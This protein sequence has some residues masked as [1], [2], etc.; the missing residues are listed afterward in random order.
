MTAGAGTGRSWLPGGVTP[1]WQGITVAAVGIIALGSSWRS[2]TYS[3]HA[4]AAIF[5]G[6]PLAAAALIYQRGA[7]AQAISSLGWPL[8]V[9][10]LALMNLVPGLNPGHSTAITT[11]S[12][13]LA[14]ASVALCFLP[15]QGLA[16]IVAAI[17]G[18]ADLALA[19]VRIIWGHATI[20]VFWFTQGA[21]AQLLSGH[22]P[23]A[24]AYST[25]T[26]GLASAHFPY[27]P[28][29]LLLAAPFRLLGDVRLTNAAAMVTVFACV[30]V[31][32]RR[33][34]GE[35]AGGRYLALALSLPFAPFMIV[36][37]WPEVYPVA[38]VALWLV[39]RDRHSRWA[40]VALAVGLC[41]VPTAAP[42][43]ALPWLWWRQA[44]QEI[45]AAF[46]GAVLICVPFAIWA[47]V[48]AFVDDT[49]MLQIHLAPRPDALSV[50]AL[51]WHLGR[52][53]L[54]WWTGITISAL[55]MIAFF[56]WG[57]R[58][59][60][61]ALML[62]AALTLVAFLTA[63]WAF[64]DYYFIVAYGFV[65][66]LCLSSHSGASAVGRA[67]PSR[68]PMSLPDPLSTS[69]ASAPNQ[70][71]AAGR[72][73]L[74][75]LETS[76]STVVSHTRE[77]RPPGPADVLSHS[78]ARTARRPNALAILAHL[79]DLTH[80]GCPKTLVHAVLLMAPHSGP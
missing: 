63:K 75:Y 20:D 1:L 76:A 29:L 27:G 46:V 33:H 57:T 65:F 68:V 50:N 80:W 66:A 4:I 79:W 53:L 22:N 19:G 37:A 44:R 10:L 61:S 72:Q 43:L 35:A 71:T 18:A 8:A 64:F 24:V 26:P 9:A 51:L 15:L 25:T 5:L 74:D 45:T 77:A 60:S 58:T 55:C 38:G 28:A 49:V 13:V 39:L 67:A 2:G 59:W 69:P 32:A 31:L 36:Q 73:R 48:R 16:W 70:R 78:A 30:A 56:L 40:V 3:S 42:L 14:G 34:A 52:P 21:T 47:G 23:Y 6:V 54:P 41:T 62:G 11:W 7:R 12:F 17:A